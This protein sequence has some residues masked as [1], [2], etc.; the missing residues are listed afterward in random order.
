MVSTFLRYIMRNGVKNGGETLFVLDECAAALS[1]LD[2]LAQAF[3]LG[4]GKGIKLYTFWQSVEQ[5]Q[6]AF[7]K[8]PNLVLDNS[9]AQIFFGVNSFPTADLVSKILGTW[10]MT[11]TT[12]N[13]SD[14]GG[15]SYQT[16]PAITQGATKQYGWSQSINFSEHQRLLLNPSEIIQLS[17]EYFIAFLKGHCPPILARRLKYYSDPLYRRLLRTSSTL[18]W[19]LFLTVIGLIVWG[20]SGSSASILNQGR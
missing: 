19:L 6:A 7:K 11:I 18:W 2:A 10:S 16:Q 3:A 15:T 12:G 9:D 5:A 17:G 20:L 14:S 4:R 8:T 13:Q 1:G